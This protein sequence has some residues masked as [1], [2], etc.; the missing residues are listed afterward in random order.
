MLHGNEEEVFRDF[1]MEHK[2]W[3][4]SKEK[5][6]ILTIQLIDQ[7]YLKLVTPAKIIR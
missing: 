2:N 1:K 4:F 6:V 5:A 3:R 7:R